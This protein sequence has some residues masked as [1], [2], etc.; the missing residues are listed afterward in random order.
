MLFYG[1]LIRWSLIAGRLPGRTTNDVKKYWNTHF[2][3]K[4]NT[5]I[6]LHPPRQKINNKGKAIIKNEIIKTLPWNLSN[7]KKMLLIGTTITK[8]L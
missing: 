5:T 4:L 7:T 8:V 3:K 6:A 2:Q 1:S